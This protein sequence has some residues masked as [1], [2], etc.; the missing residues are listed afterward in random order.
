M[1]KKLRFT[2]SAARQFGWHRQGAIHHRSE[3]ATK[4]GHAWAP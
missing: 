3:Q 2:R 1:K 4:A